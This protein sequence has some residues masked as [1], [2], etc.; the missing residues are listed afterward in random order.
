[1]AQEILIV[2][3]QAS[4]LH[5]KAD[6]RN[7]VAAGAGSG[8]S[9]VELYR[10][11]VDGS[12]RVVGRNM[13]DQS[14]VINSMLY[15]NMEYRR[16]S[17]TFHQWQDAR[18]VYGLNFPNKDEANIFGTAV[19][20]AVHT[21]S[22]G[23]SAIPAMPPQPAPTIPTASTATA[24]AATTDSIKRPEK[25]RE[26]IP[27]APKKNI[28]KYQTLPSKSRSP[29]AESIPRP[30]TTST[31]L[32]NLFDPPAPPQSQHPPPPLPPTAGAAPTTE[33]ESVD[34]QQPVI[35]SLSNTNVSQ[36]SSE[37]EGDLASQISAMKLK[38]RDSEAPPPSA[39]VS[40]DSGDFI[41]LI[42]GAKLKKREST[43]EPPPPVS[44]GGPTDEMQSKLAKR[45]SQMNAATIAPPESSIAVSPPAEPPKPPIEPPKPPKPA[46]TPLKPVV[47][48]LKPIEPTPEVKP[49]PSKRTIKK[50]PKEPPTKDSSSSKDTVSTPTKEIPDDVISNLRKE[51]RADMKKELEQFKLEIIEAIRAELR[52]QR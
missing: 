40:S 24:T 28:N 5:Y 10:N 15:P 27:E 47:E 37:A 21:L 18:F 44:N 22:S 39:P 31:P 19:E 30:E 45:L 46:P 9:R 33:A 12:Y 4:V 7:W 43:A 16:A 48:D 50:E 3:A 2:G 52:E 1:M 36:T 35:E 42:A 29:L 49:K 38:K 34:Y 23:P 25:P 14:V 8:G 32:K 26:P 20:K 6:V 41:S 17:D 13:T 11:E 51:I